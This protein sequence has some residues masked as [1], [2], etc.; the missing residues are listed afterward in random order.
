[1][2]ASEFVEF[3][4]LSFRFNYAKQANSLIFKSGGVLFKTT[5]GSDSWQ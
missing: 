5:T 1:M 4:R 3:Q 2:K